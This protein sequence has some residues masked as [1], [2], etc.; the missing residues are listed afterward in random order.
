MR[1]WSNR[2]S[3]GE[4]LMKRFIVIGLED[5]EPDVSCGTELHTGE[6]IQEIVDGLSVE[7][8]VF[9]EDGR[10]WQNNV[11]A[12]SQKVMELDS[13]KLRRL[14]DE[15]F[16]TLN[17]NDDFTLTQIYKFMQNTSEDDPIL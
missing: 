3:K 8:G 9:S 17:W 1:E 6:N 4:N 16:K 13:A 10:S 5:S 11:Y 2:T 14:F 15:H 12:G 7:E